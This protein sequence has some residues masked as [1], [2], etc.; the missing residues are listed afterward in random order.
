MIK[1]VMKTKNPEDG[2]K[3]WGI[4]NDWCAYDDD[5]I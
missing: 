4:E 5:N 2:T 1:L 3:R